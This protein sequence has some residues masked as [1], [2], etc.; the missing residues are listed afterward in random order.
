[1]FITGIIGLGIASGIFVLDIH[2]TNIV[3]E[4]PKEIKSINKVFE[5]TYKDGMYF[6]NWDNNIEY[7]VDPKLK[8]TVLINIET[9]EG[10]SNINLEIRAS[11]FHVLKLLAFYLF[12]VFKKYKIIFN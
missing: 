8:D 9:I 11:T 12:L 10:M 1:M 2:K 3:T 4:L 5:Y 6:D 7:K